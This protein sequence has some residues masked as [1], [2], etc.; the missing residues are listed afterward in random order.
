MSVGIMGDTATIK[1]FQLAGVTHS[2][3]IEGSDKVIARRS[4]RD[5]QDKK[6]SMIIV[7][8]KVSQ[9]LRKELLAALRENPIPAIV[10][11]P[12]KHESSG[13]A[14]LIES[15]TNKAIGSNIR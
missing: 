7:T 12:G 8:Q 15:I 4:F 9:L 2:A 14:R 3:L 13:H 6:L 1:G 11:I 5:L 10:E